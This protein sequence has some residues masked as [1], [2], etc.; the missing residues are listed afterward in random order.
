LFYRKK[1]KQIVCKDRRKFYRFSA[2]F[3][4]FYQN[5]LD[6]WPIL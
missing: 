3:A 2:V 1:I 4:I 6:E 5:R